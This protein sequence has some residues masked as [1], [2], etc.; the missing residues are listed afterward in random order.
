MTAAAKREV[1]GEGGY[2]MRVEIISKDMKNGKLTFVVRD[3]N[4]AFV[5]TLRRI[6]T[7]EVPVMA[8]EDVEFRKNSSA[9]YDE[10]IAHRIG[11]VPLKSDLKMYSRPEEC[12]CNGKGCAKCQLKLTLKAS[13]P[14]TV[15]ASDIKSPDPKIVPVYPEM[16]IV[17]LLKGQELEAEMTAVLGKGEEHAK[18][19][20]GLVYYKDYP[21]IKI[22]TAGESCLACIE[23]CPKSIFA[24]KD[25]KLFVQQEK[26]MECHWCN[27]CADVSNN[28]VNV[29]SNKKDFIVYV[30]SW[31]QLSPVE[32]M[33]RSVEVLDSKFES[34][35]SIFPSKKEEKAKK[36]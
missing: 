23:V 8:V 6:A 32:L 26:L 1:G 14:K 28:N 35:I 22:T 3:T 10:I 19:S 18:W 4:H 33:Q 9:L 30:E 25:G 27:A 13:G 15:Y 31:G 12:S 2:K 5:N 29:E 20:P 17:K 34:F 36:K 11:L 24:E 7:E 16:P 21:F